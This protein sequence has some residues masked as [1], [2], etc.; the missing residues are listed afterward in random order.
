[1]S[2]QLWTDGEEGTLPFRT[3]HKDFSKTYTYVPPAP[4]SSSRTLTRRWSQSIALPITYPS[5]LLTSQ[6][7]FTIWDV[8]GPGRAVPIGGTT[9]RLFNSK[10]CVLPDESGRI[11]LSGPSSGD[12]RDCSFIEAWRLIPSHTRPRQAMG[13]IE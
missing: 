9:M 1:M 7:A 3:A 4:S 8:Q 2:C 6:I 11:S 12:S 10:R 13:R 5:L